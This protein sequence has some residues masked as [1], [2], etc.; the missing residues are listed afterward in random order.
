MGQSRGRCSD[1]LSMAHRDE[2]LQNIRNTLVHFKSLLSSPL[3]IFMLIQPHSGA[4]KF[5]NPLEFPA[6]LHQYDLHQILTQVR[7]VEKENQIQPD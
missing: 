7:R 2:T 3:T 5:G 6:F 4:S 1:N